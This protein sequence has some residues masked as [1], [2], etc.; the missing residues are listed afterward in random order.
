M[1]R[2]M[3]FGLKGAQIEWVERLLKAKP[4]CLLVGDPAS[5]GVQIEFEEG[6]PDA[7]SFEAYCRQRKISFDAAPHRIYSAAE[8]N[9]ARYFLLAG[10]P[11]QLNTD[12]TRYSN[13]TACPVC[14]VGLTQAGPLVVDPQH[15][16]LP[17]RRMFCVCL[18]ESTEWI[19]ASESVALFK[20]CSGARFGD[21][22]AA[23][24]LLRPL[25]S[26]KQLI[27]ESR[28]PR[29]ARIT[30]FEEYDPPLE[31]KCSCNRAGWGLLDEAVYEESALGQA[32]DFNLTLERWYGGGPVG[33]SWPVVSQRVR[34][35]ILDNKLLRRGCF[36]PVR[37]IEKDP[38]DRHKFELPLDSPRG[39]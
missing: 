27:I 20:E 16:K 3:V 21:V 11:S 5:G 12:A 23:N 4:N 29:M 1:K 22:C 14:G 33:L 26:V 35:L 24:N 18:R 36:D 38:G 15:P 10:E 9:S 30:N 34:R 7:V 25:G 13:T 6:G 32:K 19:V 28:L 8:L 37:I 17:K 31:N 39:P 2:F